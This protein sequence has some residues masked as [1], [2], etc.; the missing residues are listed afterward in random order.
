MGPWPQRFLM[1]SGR[2]IHWNLESQ[3]TWTHL[4]FPLPC[5]KREFFPW[6]CHYPE[7]RSYRKHHGASL[8]VGWGEN[9]AGCKLNAVRGLFVKCQDKG[10]R[11]WP[12]WGRM[13]GPLWP[14]WVSHVLHTGS[15]WVTV[16]HLSWFTF[17]LLLTKLF[18]MFFTK[19]YTLFVLLV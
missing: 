2:L 8:V 14:C 13:W 4:F 7:R 11:V 9:V 5:F 12:S 3:T 17:T 16:A 15:I 10:Q 19:S 1:V 18:Q 6:A